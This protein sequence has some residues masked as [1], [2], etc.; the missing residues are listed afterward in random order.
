MYNGNGVGF[1]FMLLAP[2]VDKFDMTEIRFKATQLTLAAIACMTDADKKTIWREVA[3]EFTESK[4]RSTIRIVKYLQPQ[5][6][7]MEKFLLDQR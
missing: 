6:D 7:A 3:E 2:Y 4:D 1:F 5:I